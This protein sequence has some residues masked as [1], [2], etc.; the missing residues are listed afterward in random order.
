[1]FTGIVQKTARIK[2][3]R[4]QSGVQVVQIEKPRTC[5]LVRGG[6]VAIDGICATVVELSSR[7]F[8]V[9]F[10]PETLRKTTARSFEKGSRVN[11]ELPMR[12]GDRVEGHFVQGH[13][14]ATGLVESIEKEGA[15]TLV[16]I[17]VPGKLASLITL[18]GSA[19]INGTSLTV[20]RR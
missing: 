17:R 1:M 16:T 18:H 4:M 7:D 3:A 15:S 19:A 11:L 12:F 14:D 10:M 9:E 2:S 20:A 8:A 13:I 5:Q 6:S